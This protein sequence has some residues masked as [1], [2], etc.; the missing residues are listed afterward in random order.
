MHWQAKSYSDA[1]NQS[2]Q[3]VTINGAEA[4]TKTN[5]DTVY[6]AKTDA[7]ETYLTKTDAGSTYATK[8]YVQNLGLIT[9]DEAA[10]EFVNKHDA[11]SYAKTADVA[12]TYVTKSD[13]EAYAKTTDVSA[14]YLTKTEAES[15]YA[16][17]TDTPAVFTSDGALKFPDGTLFYPNGMPG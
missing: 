12:G 7:Q 13:A 4:M 2:A 10:A 15:T 6:L 11:E 8:V 14:T 16:K 9:S 1:A 3:A 17:K 5:A